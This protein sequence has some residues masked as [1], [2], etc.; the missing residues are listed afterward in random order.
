[1]CCFSSWSILLVRKPGRCSTSLISRGVSHTF[2]LLPKPE[3]LGFTPDYPR[4]RG[5]LGGAQSPLLPPKG[6][7][8]IRTGVLTCLASSAPLCLLVPAPR[9]V[10]GASEAFTPTH[11]GRMSPSSGSTCPLHL[12][13]SLLLA[14]QRIHP[15]DKGGEKYCLCNP[16]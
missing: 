3:R 1:L 14:V 13:G 10:S 16:I 6:R 12:V 8:I 2:T 7:P 4:L 9:Q 5:G 11:L 15:G